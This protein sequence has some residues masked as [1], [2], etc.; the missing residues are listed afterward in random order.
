MRKNSMLPAYIP[1]MSLVY[2]DLTDE[3]KKAVAREKAVQLDDSIENL[4]FEIN[5]LELWKT[6]TRDESRNSWEKISEC[7]LLEN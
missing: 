1:H 6:D 2:G 4:S 7:S 3:E 5:R